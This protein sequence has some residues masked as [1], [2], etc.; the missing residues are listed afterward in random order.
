MQ[1]APL[2]GLGVQLS[3]GGPQVIESLVELT[4]YPR[5][6]IAVV[7]SSATLYH[8]T[9]GQ[10]VILKADNSLGDVVDDA[11]FCLYRI[12]YLDESPPLNVSYVTRLNVIEGDQL[13]CALPITRNHE[14]DYL[15]LTL[16][17]SEQDRGGYVDLSTPVRIFIRPALRIL[18]IEP[19]ILPAGQPTQG[20]KVHIQ[21][22]EGIDP[23]LH[24]LRVGEADDLTLI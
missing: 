9:A 6:I 23:D 17:A 19:R 14:L 3:L 5:A 18:L 20:H 15:W 21:K 1:G 24:A 7:D 8:D 13:S 2:A 4:F 10:E 12:D 22:Q 16:R 11:I